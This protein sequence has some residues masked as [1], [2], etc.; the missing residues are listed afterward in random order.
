MP[1]ASLPLRPQRGIAMR[2]RS[3]FLFLLL[4]VVARTTAVSAA[5]ESDEVK[6]ER[7]KFKG[8]W[9]V[10][11]YVVDGKEFDSDVIK[12]FEFV[13]EMDK[14]TIKANSQERDSTFTLDLMAKPRRIDMVFK[15]KTTIGI[16]EFDGENR[17]QLALAR[18]GEKKRPKEFVSKAR[19]EVSWFTLRRAK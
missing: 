6:K 5:P 10:I 9:H 15:N 7:E 11:T 1:D 18:E 8:R 4:V 16:Y 12:R 3:L 14:V 17:L 19:S 2:L 13:F